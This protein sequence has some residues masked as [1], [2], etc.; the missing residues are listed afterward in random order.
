MCIFKLSLQVQIENP[1]LSLIQFLPHFLHN[2]A[3]NLILNFNL[4]F[5]SL[6]SS[7]ILI[8]LVSQDHN[9]RN[10]LTLQ[11]HLCQNQK[12]LLAGQTSP[13]LIK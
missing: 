6:Y 12:I 8:C 11:T 1:E 5:T 13:I 2:L 9:A 10:G 3:S 7:L 4:T